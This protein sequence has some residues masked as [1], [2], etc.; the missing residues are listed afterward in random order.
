M[1]K[2]LIFNIDQYLLL[3]SNW[4][5]SKQMQHEQKNAYCIPLHISNLNT[6]YAGMCICWATNA[7]EACTSPSHAPNATQPH[8]DSK[9]YRAVIASHNIFWV[10]YHSVR[11]ADEKKTKI[12][13]TP[14]AWLI[15]P[16]APTNKN[17]KQANGELRIRWRVKGGLHWHVPD[18]HVLSDDSSM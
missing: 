17:I 6:Q 2:K 5:L 12:P 8:R 3:P 11:S 13:P 7:H 10:I 4:T 18:M 14:F 1:N 9:N 15:W 16:K